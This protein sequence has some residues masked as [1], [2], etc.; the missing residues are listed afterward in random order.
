M[1]LKIM[2]GGEERTFVGSLR[3]RNRRAGV[4]Q[5]VTGVLVAAEPFKLRLADRL[6]PVHL[7]LGLAAT[8]RGRAVVTTRTTVLR[9]RER[10][11]RFERPAS[12][13]QRQA[14]VDAAGAPKDLPEI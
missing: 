2:D 7:G 11:K 8:A 1:P 10:L 4:D 5:L 6:E 9:L 14:R 13:R 12:V 3:L